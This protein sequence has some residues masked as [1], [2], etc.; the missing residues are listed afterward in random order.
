LLLARAARL[1]PPAGPTHRVLA[2]LFGIALP[3]GLD[4]PVA[5]VTRAVDSGASTGDYWLRADPVHLRADRSGLVLVDIADFP[6]SSQDAQALAAAVREPLA[7]VG[8]LEALRPGRW[9]LRLKRP[10]DL[11]THELDEVAG[12]DIRGRLPEG[13]DAPAWHRLLNEIQVRLHDHA[14]NREREARGEPAAN[15]LWFWGGGVLPA[16]AGRRWSRVCGGGI[17]AE[18]LAQ[19]SGAPFLAQAEQLSAAIAGVE[20]DGW[21]LVVLD[22]CA[23]ALRYHDLKSWTEGIERLEAA[24]FKPCLRLLGKGR[25]RRLEILTGGFRFAVTPLWLLRFWRRAAPLARFCA[26]AV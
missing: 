16:P 6:L 3:A 10:A 18:G 7:A 11:R 22:D 19:A 12:R 4:A 23:A 9:Y 1:P 8:E 25:L 13:P 24:W 5:A 14:V 21:V 15:S 2:E 26:G 17:Y 20:S